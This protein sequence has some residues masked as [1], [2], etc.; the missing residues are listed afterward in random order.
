M[1]LSVVLRNRF[2]CFERRTLSKIDEKK[3]YMVSGNQSTLKDLKTLSARPT[4]SGT[5]SYS[6]VQSC[7]WL[8]RSL[9]CRTLIRAAFS[10]SS[11]GGHSV[12]LCPDAPHVLPFPRPSY[13]AL[14]PS[15]YAPSRSTHSVVRLHPSDELQTSHIIVAA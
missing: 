12:L 10:S 7:P 1:I 6:V 9:R 14:F 4:T 11:H 15:P 2:E 5:A 13:R 3:R 8:M